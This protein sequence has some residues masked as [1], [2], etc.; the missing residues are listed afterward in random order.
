MADK[1][2]FDFVSPERRLA[3]NE[4]DRVAIPGMEGDMTALPNHAPFLTTLRPGIVAA[5]DGGTVTEYVVTG[6]FAEISPAGTTVLAEEAVLRGDVTKDWLDS[7]I[8]EAEE[9]LAS[10]GE[11]GKTAA[12]LRINDFRALASQIGLS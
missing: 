4:V 6:G 8:S 11:D 9:A 12:A 2:Q 10:A 7:K 5:H 3:S 1:M